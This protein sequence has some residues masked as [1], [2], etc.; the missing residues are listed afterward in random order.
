MKQVIIGIDPGTIITGFGIIEVAPSGLILLDYG[1]IKPPAKLKLSE[2][3]RIIHQSVATLI[4]KYNPDAMA[5][6]LQFVRH[7]P[8]SAL[9]LGMA[10]G[11]I[12][13]AATLKKIEVFE[14]SPKSAKLAV[15]GSGSSSKYQVQA[16]IQKQFCLKAPPTPEDAADALSLAICHAHAAQTARAL[17]VL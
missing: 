6:E 2:R 8:Q 1:S 10:R 11:V 3:Y 5:V 13:L 15:T 7:N 17:G 14:Y 4:D 12:V 16:M 9:K